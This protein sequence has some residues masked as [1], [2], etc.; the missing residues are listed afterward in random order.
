[1]TRYLFFLVLGFLVFTISCSNEKN[2]T[3]PNIV[4]IVSEDNG[5]F[6]GCYGDSNAITPN[7]DKLASE[8]LL[9]ENAFSNAPVCAPSRST[10]VTGM[11]ASSLGTQQM[12]CSNTIPEEF[13]FFPAYLK[14]SGYFTSNRKKKDY[15]IP[16]RTNVWD[17]DHFWNYRDMLKGRKENQPFFVQY[18]TFMS[19]ESRIHFSREKGMLPYFINEAVE[20]MTGNPASEQ[21]VDSLN[22]A[23]KPGD[24]IPPPYHPK[25]TEMY[26]D[27]ARY[28]SCITMMD[29][30]I[31]LLL[32]NLENDNLLENT[33]IFYFSDHA[34]VL[35]R[36]KRFTFESGLHVPF[37]VRFPEKYEH[38]APVK[39]GS[40]I[41]RIIS[42]VDLAPT[43]LN[44]AGLEIPAN[45]QGRPFLGPQSS[46]EKRY[47]FGFRGRMDERFDF[48]RTV[49]D[50]EYRYIINYNPH[51]IWGQHIGYLWRAKS[52]RSW[53]RAFKNNETNYLQ[54]RFWQAKPVEELYH[55][56]SDPH[57]IKN[58]ANNPEYE[59]VLKRMRKACEKWI[60]EINDK[61]FIPEGE[62]LAAIK[63]TNGYD[64]FTGNNYDLKKI[65]AVADKA[66]LGEPN[67]LDSL[68]IAMESKNPTIR[69]WGAIGCCVLKERAKPADEQLI[70]LTLDTSPDIRITAAEALYH[71]GKVDLAKKT[72]KE[73][74][75][76]NE[77]KNS[78]KAAKIIRTRALNVID[79]MK[80]E[81]IG[82]FNTELKQL[83][84]PNS[85][86]YDKSLA[87]KLLIN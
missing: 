27:W 23:F 44:L 18:N 43:A 31:G 51:K 12:R 74:V 64:F 69:F 39:A 25:T 48:C 79:L 84:D 61:N 57:N 73:T 30:E 15:N 2:T 54:S 86:D 46:K 32:D 66:I 82:Y 7:L 76:I 50:E 70:A 6:L 29:H 83:A 80:K 35:A 72:L 62:Y 13:R 19:H 59:S 42:F 36:S 17:V 55:I 60:L 65:K 38:L 87:N 33:I 9:Y 34:G 20:K 22:R 3:P 47:A 77:Y 58:L 10:I 37:I 5:P 78:K 45:Y 41:E 67:N 8:G 28:Y 71:I 81:D 52:V 68:I 16:D 4:F 63:D 53:E 40:R 11:Y 24:I 56:K 26:E 49:R 85:W 1:M 14:Q 75:K 21:L